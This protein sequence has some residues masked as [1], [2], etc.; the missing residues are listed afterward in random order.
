MPLY[1]AINQNLEKSFHQ[2][3]IAAHSCSGA[4]LCVSLAIFLDAACDVVGH[5]ASPVTLGSLGSLRTTR[6][7]GT[8]GRGNH[9]VV[10]KAEIRGSI[11]VSWNRGLFWGE[12]PGM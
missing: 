12:T 1:A 11:G 10:V 2:P 6:T 4:V 8:T 7:L 5:R 9:R 3:L